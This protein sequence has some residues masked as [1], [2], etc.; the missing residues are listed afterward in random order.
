MLWCGLDI[1][2]GESPNGLN[3]LGTQLGV[4]AHLVDGSLPLSDLGTAEYLGDRLARIASRS[5]P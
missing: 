3:R 2:G 4:A 5:A 1:P